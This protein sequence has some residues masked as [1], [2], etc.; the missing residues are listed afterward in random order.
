LFEP[1]R[2]ADLGIRLERQPAPL[3][4]VWQQLLLPRRL[5]RGDVDLLWSPLH[6]LPRRL[7]VPGVVTVHDL[8]ALHFPETLTWKIRWS[9]LP[10]LEPSIE[11]AARI[12]TVSASVA[13][14]IAAAWPRAAAKTEVI[15]NG[16]DPAFCPASE[17]AIAATRQRL[18]LP[19]GF[20][21][22]V[23]TIEPRKNV[24]LL[25]D[26]WQALRAEWPAAPPLVIAGP[27]GWHSS[28]LVRRLDRLAGEGL[29]RLG[30]LP[31]PELIAVV[32]AATL[33]VFPSLYEGFGLPV[34]EAMACGVP[35]VVA[36]R[37]S[38]PEVVGDA[39]LCVD[40]DDPHELVEAL[41]QLL[42]DKERMQRLAAL[43]RER[44]QGFSW[45][46]AGKRLAGVFRL[47]LAGSPETSR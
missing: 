22:Y 47:A 15:W 18:G 31:R 3:G 4:V 7:P 21:L 8:A 11:R 35:V 33:F 46:T 26:A 24:E 43:G 6:T 45:R 38:L 16:V 37:S 41:V 1:Q 27:E 36:R 25:V 10:F 34:A 44:A 29:R 12:V 19:A 30:H 2:L 40:A 14:E 42:P 5:A 32:Q 20:L 28:A 13:R 9:L 23:G 39:G 17:G